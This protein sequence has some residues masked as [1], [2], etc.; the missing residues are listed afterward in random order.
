M[1]PGAR[2]IRDIWEDAE[3]GVKELA[4]SPVIYFKLKGSKKQYAVFQD[5]VR[6][7]YH[8]SCS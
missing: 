2:V 7:S 8:G 5:F 4:F 3:K 6:E 1:E